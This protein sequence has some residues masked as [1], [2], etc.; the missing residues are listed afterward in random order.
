MGTLLRKE[1]VSRSTGRECE[2]M[3]RDWE[4]ESEELELD[5]EEGQEEHREER[6]LFPSGIVPSSITARMSTRIG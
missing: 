5:R 3:E 4:E 2:G 6:G 1:G